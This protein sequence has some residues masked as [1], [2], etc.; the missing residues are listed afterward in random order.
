MA[1]LNVPLLDIPTE[2]VN[3]IRVKSFLLIKR[4]AS[5]RDVSCCM[6]DGGGDM[7]ESWR[8]EFIKRGYQQDV[9][10][11]VTAQYLA[12]FNSL[13]EKRLVLRQDKQRG[14]YCDNNVVILSVVVSNNVVNFGG[15]NSII[16]TE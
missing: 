11:E 15:L 13:D 3:L 16:F 5:T 4:H 8:K 14:F 1:F 7:S 2:T 10:A 9:I 12:D 6:K